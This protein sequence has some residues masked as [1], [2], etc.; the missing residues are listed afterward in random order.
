MNGLLVKYVCIWNDDEIQADEPD[1]SGG[2]NESVSL[3]VAQRNYSEIGVFH[4]YAGEKK[5]ICCIEI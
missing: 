4:I 3:R 2:P 1:F 5:P